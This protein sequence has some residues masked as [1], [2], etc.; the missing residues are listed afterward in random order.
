VVKNFQESP[1]HE[2]F[3]NPLSGPLQFRKREV[4]AVRVSW[5]ATV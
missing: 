5:L 4:V 3:Q 2:I 1:F